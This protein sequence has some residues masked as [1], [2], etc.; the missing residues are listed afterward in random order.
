MHDIMVETKPH[1]RKVT[2]PEADQC[3]GVVGGDEKLPYWLK[4]QLEPKWQIADAIMKCNMSN[5]E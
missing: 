3:K 1:T 2:P 5:P 4:L